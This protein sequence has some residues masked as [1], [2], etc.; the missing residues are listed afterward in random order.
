M[1]IGLQ[2]RN[3]GLRK[4]INALMLLQTRVLTMEE[5]KYKYGT[6]KAEKN[7]V[8]IGGVNMNIG[9]HFIYVFPRNGLEEWRYSSSEHTQHHSD[10]DFYHC[11]I[12]ATRL[13]WINDLLILGMAQEGTRW[14]W[15]IL[16]GQKVIKCSKNV[17]KTQVPAWKE[18][19]HWPSWG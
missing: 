3:S 4:W 17:K 13:T 6:G 9:S 11:P 16:L 2:L 5:G 7:L 19:S 18:G 8:R 12:K 15:S 10:L 1:S 14:A